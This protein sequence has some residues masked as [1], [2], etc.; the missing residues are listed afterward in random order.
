MSRAIPCVGCGGTGGVETAHDWKCH[1]CSGSGI[2][3]HM[4]EA[5]DLVELIRE[6]MNLRV[7]LNCA[8]R[9]SGLPAGVGAEWTDADDAVCRAI[10][11]ATNHDYESMTSGPRYVLR[12]NGNLPAGFVQRFGDSE[13]A[14]FLLSASAPKFAFHGAFRSRS[15]ASR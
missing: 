2:D 5:L 13:W 15:E 14:R 11:V 8:A 6:A 4:G 1:R 10:G 3:P 9:D 12:R 7:R